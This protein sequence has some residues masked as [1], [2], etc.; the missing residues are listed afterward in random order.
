MR[1]P[2]VVHLAADSIRTRATE[3]VTEGGERPI[4]LH[5]Q[6]HMTS[7]YERDGSGEKESESGGFALGLFFSVLSAMLGW[8]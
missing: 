7:D 1:R 3:E 8:G 5:P 2:A 6:L 4:Q